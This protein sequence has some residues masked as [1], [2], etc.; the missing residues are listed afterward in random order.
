[1]VS[2]SRALALQKELLTY[3]NIVG[4]HLVG[5][6]VYGAC[7]GI[8]ERGERTYAGHCP[9]KATWRPE[10]VQEREAALPKRFRGKI[11]YCP[12]P[13][14]VAFDENGEALRGSGIQ[15]RAAMA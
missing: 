3:D 10:S 11:K 2:Y 13:W 7:W 5:D 15:L 4:I 12:P 6:Q 8:N 14:F 1:V 9:R